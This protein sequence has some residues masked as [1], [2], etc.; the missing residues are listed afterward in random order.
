MTAGQKKRILSQDT[1][2]KNHQH[3]YFSNSEL[4]K[5]VTLNVS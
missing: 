2:I 4:C 1:G 5:K 3:W